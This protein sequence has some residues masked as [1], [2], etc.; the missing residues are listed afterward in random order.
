MEPGTQI[1]QD[2]N[3]T[4]T[5]SITL[6]PEDAAVWNDVDLLTTTNQAESL[7]MAV[8]W[9]RA[10]MKTGSP[11]RTKQEWSLLLQD[12]DRLR[13]QADAAF[14][15]AIRQHR[16][17]GGSLKDLEISLDWPHTT[18]QDRRK[19]AMDPTR[20]RYTD[21]VTGEHDRDT[22]HMRIADGLAAQDAAAERRRAETDTND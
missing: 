11:L 12:L 22:T 20:Y 5:V 16:A 6:A 9:V 15:A 10:S 3:G 1:R 17:A 18:A 19:R 21:W 2:E 4:V 14:A 7:L 13:D 8:A